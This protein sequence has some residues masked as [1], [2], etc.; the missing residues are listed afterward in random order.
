[1]QY[2]FIMAGSTKEAAMAVCPCKVEVKFDNVATSFYCHIP[3]YPAE[4]RGEMLVQAAINLEEQKV[5]DVLTAIYRMDRGETKM[6]EY[7]HQ[8][9]EK[10]AFRENND[11]GTR[12]LQESLALKVGIAYQRFLEAQ[13]KYMEYK[14]V[15]DQG[16]KFLIALYERHNT[17]LILKE[18]KQSAQ[19]NPNADEAL[20]LAREYVCAGEQWVRQKSYDFCNEQYI[21]KA[22][23]L[24]ELRKQY[25]FDCRG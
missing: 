11:L 22:D 17:H 12:S 3:R 21:A 23:Q 5:Q 7:F 15:H 18:L 25:D 9:I 14:A 2:L 8:A 4:T 19:S 16:R 20:L 24:A 1:M 10:L 13:E 6:A